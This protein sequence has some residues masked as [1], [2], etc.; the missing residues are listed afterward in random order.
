ML[1]EG[2]IERLV[3]DVA[4]SRLGTSRIDR[5]ESRQV[6]DSTG[7]PAILITI[8][9]EDIQEMFGR[10]GGSL[11]FKSGVWDGLAS[12]GDERIPPIAYLSGNETP[13]FDDS[14]RP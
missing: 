9:F 4:A 10:E 2:E 13:V 3:R 1:D 11:D 5:V 7:E 6:I 8:V 14:G 12:K